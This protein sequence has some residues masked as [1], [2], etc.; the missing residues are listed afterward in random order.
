VG[1]DDAGVVVLAAFD[2][3]SKGDAKVAL[4]RYPWRRICR[5]QWSSSA[6]CSRSRCAI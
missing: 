4:C 6:G 2:V 5:G 3:S 1:G